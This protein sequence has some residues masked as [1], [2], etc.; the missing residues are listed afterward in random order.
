MVEY[1]VRIIRI[2]RLEYMY[3]KQLE[4]QQDVYL[5]EENRSTKFKKKKKNPG[6]NKL[7]EM[8]RMCLRAFALCMHAHE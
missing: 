1:Q 8:A 5:Y 7:S 4:Q 6:F 2:E 3:F